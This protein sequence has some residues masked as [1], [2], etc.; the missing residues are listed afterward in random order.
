[1][2]FERPAAG[3]FRFCSQVASK[4]DNTPA[5]A[6]LKT[7]DIHRA[8]DD[9]EIHRQMQHDRTSSIPV[10]LPPLQPQPAADEG[11]SGYAKGKSASLRV[12]P[13]RVGKVW[14]CPICN[15]ATCKLK[16]HRLYARDVA[17]RAAR[18]VETPMREIAA[19][20]V[21]PFGK[22][23]IKMT[24]QLE[25]LYRQCFQRWSGNFKGPERHLFPTSRYKAAYSAASSDT[26]LFTAL[27]S[28][29][30]TQLSVLRGKDMD[31]L[32]LRLQ[33]QALRLQ[34]QACQDG[35]PSDARIM[36]A[37]CIMSNHMANSNPQGILPHMKAIEVFIRQRGG[38]QYLGMEGIIAD[39]L[40]YADH[41][42]AIVY[43][44][45]P[46]Y[47]L[48][49]PALDPP[50]TVKRR[51]GRGFHTLFYNTDI[52]DAMLQACR[53]TSCLTDIYDRACKRKETKQESM[54]FGYLAAVVEYQLGVLNAQNHDTG[55]LEE[56]LTLALLLINHTVFR[57]YG[58]IAPSVP[59]VEAR[60]WACFDKIFSHLL[61]Q[62]DL[63]DLLLWLAFTGTITSLRRE[64]PFV[65]KAIVVLVTIYSCQ[66]F[67]PFDD[68]RT[69]MDMFVWSAP[70]QE[71][72]FMKLWQQVLDRV[73]MPYMEQQQQK[74][75]TEESSLS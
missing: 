26:A 73:G 13:T 48:P 2:P 10:S 28:L 72:Q 52:G 43:N 49:L 11:L 8:H 57:N 66:K 36:T 33:N 9:L 34:Y 12:Q 7:S 45:H 44:T 15:K 59:L 5:I 68:V 4:V 1:M 35:N 38:I 6:N 63:T 67:A 65:D 46:T 62:E 61:G 70:V 69:T 18:P 64:C 58:Q 42:R 71:H 16:S 17:D 24:P 30:S 32:T 50:K 60:F 19:E 39:N 3:A 55:T 37:L 23:P 54:Y 47:E 56:C 29:V 41:T 25:Q 51:L 27:L 53:D 31:E 75:K 14:R 40:T 20:K 74:L 21:D 22:F